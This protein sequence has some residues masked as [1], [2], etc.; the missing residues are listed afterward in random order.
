MPGHGRGAGADHHPY[1]DFAEGVRALLVDKDNNPRWT[2][3][4]IEDV[5]PALVE[6]F[7]A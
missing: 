6:A 7:F 3:A 2:P 5:E 1:P 4:R